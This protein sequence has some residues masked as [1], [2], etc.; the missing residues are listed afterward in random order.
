MG[1]RREAM[2]AGNRLVDHFGA[3]LDEA[4]AAGDRRGEAAALG[5]L[6]DAFLLAGQASVSIGHYR[7][8]LEVAEAA[9]DEGLQAEL[10]G[11]QG[12]AW[13]RVGNSR[14][15]LA[16]LGRALAWASETGDRE[17]VDRFG[18]EYLRAYLRGKPRKFLFLGFAMHI[19]GQPEE[20]LECLG[21][22]LDEAREGDDR[23]AE[24]AI[25]VSLAALSFDTARSHLRRAA[26]LAGEIDAGDK[27]AEIGSLLAAW[28]GE[29]ETLGRLEGELCTRCL[30][31]RETERSGGV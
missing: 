1:R 30:R 10:W 25:L 27:G 4:R 22:A 23:Q 19:I 13:N 18:V 3:A 24:L 31:H 17:L 21:D 16:C 7:K 12:I 20:A 5:D 9:G 14:E 2:A 6:G 28:S 29:G 8:A 15:A 11:R 26:K